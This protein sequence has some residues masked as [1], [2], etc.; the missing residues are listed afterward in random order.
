MSTTNEK[1][2]HSLYVWDPIVRLGHWLLV[3]A[4]VIAYLSEGDVMPLHSWA[5]YTVAAIVLVRI[6]W[7]LI[8]S[9]HAR[10]TDFIYAPKAIFGYLSDLIK[11]KK[12]YFVGHNPAGGAMVIALLMSL[13]MTAYSGIAV[14]A[15]EEHAGPLANVYAHVDNTPRLGF[16][17]QANAS[18]DLHEGHKENHENEAEEFWEEIHEFFANFTLLLVLIHIG[19]VIASSRV[20]QENLVKAMIT[21]K[22]ER[23]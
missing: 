19:G 17:S 2:A 6:V 15:F 8:G 20:G 11:G 18:G 4:F 12:Q 13:G 3:T 1:S 10:F 22:K 14:Y 9:K 23:D 7:G 16:I 5:G 21:G